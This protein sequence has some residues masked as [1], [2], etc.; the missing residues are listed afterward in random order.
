MIREE[1]NW[2]KMIT[3][4]P[5]V[6]CLPKIKAIYLIAFGDITHLQ[7]AAILQWNA[8]SLRSKSADFRKLV[9]QHAFPAL[10]LVEAGGDSHHR[11]ANYFVYT[12]SRSAG[13]SIAMICVRK[14][15]PSVEL[16]ASTPN[17]PDFE[18]Q[19]AS[20]SISVIM[21][22][23]SHRLMLPYVPICR[24]CTCLW[25]LL[26]HVV[27]LRRITLCGGAIIVTAVEIHALR[28][29]IE[30]SGLCLLNDGSI[31]FFRG[32]NY[33]SCLDLISYVLETS[34]AA[35]SGEQMQRQKEVTTSEYLS[36]IVVHAVHRLGEVLKWQT[37]KHYGS[38]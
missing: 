21:Y 2:D 33:S 17:I 30:K 23:L 27:I 15:L 14:N 13:L 28:K 26:S 5:Q 9:A 10:F 20:V 29:P 22:I 38:I 1:Q 12:S 6:N 31:I 7:N 16:G 19:I 3:A 32:Y 25:A 24:F 11:L 4:L 18:V 34:Q 8:N 37:G 36:D 35:Q